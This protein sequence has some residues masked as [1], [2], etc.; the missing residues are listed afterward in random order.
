MA[1]MLFSMKTRHLNEHG[2]KSPTFLT[3]DCNCLISNN[4][5]NH[6]GLEILL[7]SEQWRIWTTMTR[8]YGM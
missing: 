1:D 2:E 6:A 5:C 7:G 8:S 3:D 4:L